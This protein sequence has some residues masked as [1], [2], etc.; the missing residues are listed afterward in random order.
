MPESMKNDDKSI[1]KYILNNVLE[2][3]PI[4]K[5]YEDL[6]KVIGNDSIA[7][8]D[9]QFWYYRFLS[10][11]QDLD[12]DRSSEP[13]P[14]QFS[15]LPVDAV[16][17]IVDK[18]EV[19]ERLVL[20]RVSKP[21]Q[22]FI[23]KQVF[24][25]TSIA[26]NIDDDLIRVWFGEEQI[27][28]AKNDEVVKSYEK[29]CGVRAA[30]ILYGDESEVCD[31]LACFLKNRKLQLECFNLNIW[32]I[33]SCYAEDV[34]TFLTKFEYTLRSLKHQIAVRTL[35]IRPEHPDHVLSILPYLRPGYLEVILINGRRLEDDWKSDESVHKVKQIVQ[36]DQ[37]K[38]AEELILEYSLH[39]FPDE[40][41]VQFKK[42]WILITSLSNNQLAHIG[43][44]F[45]DSPI[46]EHCHFE[47]RDSDDYRSINFG[48][49]GPTAGNDRTVRHL[50]IP[51]TDKLLILKASEYG[52]VDFERQTRNIQ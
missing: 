27:L 9:F 23:E 3:V 13:E 6:C 50:M 48:V 26:V 16:E 20:R 52:E 49:P 10:G 42:Y 17:L 51:N 43:F 44:K 46:L 36:L 37:W 41:L 28:Y 35:Q 22:E 2:K 8:Y 24:N 21:L 30:R 40:V 45:A 31:D 29:E 33:D 11:K 5:S 18:L 25:C 39:R 15:D 1:R 38:Q 34:S 12:F 14:F 32:F 47:I 7:F 4:D 19:V